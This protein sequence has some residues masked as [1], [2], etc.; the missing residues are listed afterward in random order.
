MINATNF[1]VSIS[2]GFKKSMWASLAMSLFSCAA[3][4][5][6]YPVSGVWVARD[7][8]FPGSTAGACLILKKFGVDGALAQRFPNLMIFS[9]DKRF[10]VRRDHL[11]ER[12]IRS[13]KSAT[14][15]R[16]QVTEWLGKHS[17]P[18]SKKQSFTLKVVDPTTIEITE[19][20]VSTQLFKC[21]SHSQSL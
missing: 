19:G 5:Q 1:K 4:A 6:T 18:F 9:K 17:L 15:G 12:H 16:F 21:S 20:K 13:V 8:R 10:E 14:D 11:A 7:D 3:W 2:F